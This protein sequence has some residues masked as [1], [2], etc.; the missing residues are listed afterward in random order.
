VVE[1]AR[2]LAELRGVTVVE[3]AQA[4]ADNFRRLCLPDAGLR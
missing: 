3:I 1:T 2:K 4:T